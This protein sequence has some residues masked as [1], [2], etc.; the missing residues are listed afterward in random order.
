MVGVV[1]GAKF[2]RVDAV[3]IARVGATV[4]VCLGDF[5]VEFSSLD[6]DREG[7]VAEVVGIGLA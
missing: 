1:G 3:V 4:R 6:E 2:K 5:R 7:P